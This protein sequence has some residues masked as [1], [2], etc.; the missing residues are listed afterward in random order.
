MKQKTF[1]QRAATAL[2][3][4]ALSATT[5]WAQTTETVS[6]IDADGHEQ[7]VT[8]TVLT[9]SENSLLN[10]PQTN[11]W[12]VVNSN[13][14]YTGRQINTANANII[15]KDNCTM[16]MSYDDGIPLY[17][18]DNL[19]IYGQSGGTGK[20]VVNSSWTSAIAGDVYTFTVNGGIVEAKNTDTY[21]RGL[22][23][24]SLVF[25]GGKLK[26][27][28]CNGILGK[29]GSSKT[30][31]LNW[32]N[33]TDRVYISGFN[34]IS[35]VTVGGAG[36]KCF[37]D[38]DGN[39][40]GGTYTDNFSTLAGKELQPATAYTLTLGSGIT[41]TTEP[42]FTY[43][44]VDY[45]AGTVTLGHADRTGYLF[46]GYTVNGTAIDGNTFTIT[47]D[48]TVAATFAP[49]P[50]HFSV[51]GDEYTIKTPAG[52]GVFCDALQDNDTYNRF[53]GKTVLLG[54]D[55]EVS[56]MAGSQYHDFCGT[57]DG[58][59][60]TLTF[61]YGEDGNPANDEYA[62]PFRNVDGC[63]IKNL[64]VAGDIY[65]SAKYAAGLV[66]QN[67]GELTAI[68]NCL[69]SVNIHSTVS[70]D[71]THGGFVAAASGQ[72]TITGCAFNGR[73][74][75]AATEKVGGF[76]GWRNSGAEI[77]NSLFIPAE[78][79][80]KSDGSATFA[81]NKVDTYNCYYTYPLFN[82]NYNPSYAPYDPADADH[83]DK[84]NNGH[85][86]RT[87]AAAEGVTI[88]VSPV[89]EATQTYTVS[90]ITAYATGITR[91]VGSDA[92]FYYGQGD[93]VGLKLSTTVDTNAPGYVFYYDA[94]AGTLSGNDT[95]GYTLTMPDA[96]VTISAVL[97]PIDW[98]T[99]STGA[100]WTNAYII[101]NK[102]QLDML[103]HRVNAGNH[104]NGKYFKLGADITYTHKDANAE[105]AATETNYTAIGY[106]TETLDRYFRGHFDGQGHT[107]SGIRIYKGGTDYAD[108]DQGLFG[109]IDGSSAEVK[110]VV[111]ADARITAADCIGGIV[112]YNRNGTV[113]GCHVLSDVTI[114]A[115][116]NE[117]SCFGGI[118]GY[119]YSYGTVAG[120]TSAASITTTGS[121]YECF[122]GVVG[123]NNATVSDCLYFGTTLEGTNNVGAIVGYN[124]DYGTV[125]NCYFTSTTITGKNDKGNALANAASAVGDNDGTVTQCGLARTVTA[126]TDVT[127]DAIA[128]TGNATTYGDGITDN[129]YRITAYSGGGIAYRANNYYGS[130]AVLSLTLSNNAG[131]APLGYQ[132]AY[133]AS[134]GTLSGNTLTMPDENVT[135][136]V[137]T[138][139]PRSTGSAVIVAYVDEN[140]QT[141]DIDAI[142]LDGTES[143]DAYGSVELAAGAYYVGTDINYTNYIDF[144]NDAILILGDG[145]TMTV[146][147]GN[148]NAIHTDYNLTIC[149][150]A[151]GTGKLNATST[152]VGYAGIRVING[153]LTIN[154]GTVTATA[155]NGDGT[156]I[157]VDNG[158]VT[159]NGGNVNANGGGYGI[160]ASN[161]IIDGGNVTANGRNCGIG[162]DVITLGWTNAS[163]HIYANSY[164]TETRIITINDGHQLTDAD[165]KHY[166]GDEW[167]VDIN[168]KHLY[169]YVENLNLAARQAPDGN[170]W[171]TF[172]CGHTSYQIDANENACAY[173]ATY[174]DDQLTLHRLGKAVPKA[175]AVIIVAD[176]NEV[177]MTAATLDAFTGSNDLRGVD[178]DS[179]VADIRNSLGEGT[180]YVLGMTTV[181][182]EQHFGFHRYTATEMPARKAFVHVA[183]A[184]GSNA[185]AL[186]RGISI[187]F[188][189]DA[190]GV[191]EVI[192]VSEVNDNSWYTINGVKLNGKPSK[193]GLYIYKGR[194]VVIK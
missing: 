146:N 28:G 152:K 77:R 18:G 3:T 31:T 75:G 22:I 21:G 85:A 89:G 115:V 38:A 73:L 17:L 167:A 193:S 182:N 102:D 156:G 80:V 153:N 180:L 63:T 129:D 110:N 5:A 15:L 74:L 29:T 112:G 83:P 65:T 35:S 116:Q 70:G 43:S 124:D 183:A 34:N 189:D 148:Y 139:H 155:T 171:T 140:G 23:C 97:D 46:S 154:G 76:I 72:I 134:A 47:A 191:E 64:H 132:Y 82:S 186:T 138:S 187:E 39:Y 147:Y 169:P 174:A 131:Q 93:A 81:R 12:F 42:L 50:D 172:Y 114:H 176:N 30:V 52:W 135:I 78:V 159:I 71:G 24:G 58:Q 96:D 101:Y 14:S 125:E 19:T 49:D 175:T 145:A 120:C 9:G 113:T 160:W 130:G 117:G 91:T 108:V 2:L 53:S 51:S 45:Y 119:N 170:Y 10:N 68:V 123:Q 90:G 181:N 88:D 105:G 143:V 103:A 32:R 36:G 118:V 188:G 11:G 26:L 179:P 192:E 79:T 99:Q 185:N 92:T 27:E 54:N 144:T 184:P 173:T 13:I 48:A 164:N 69:S 162:A 20:L 111:L 98:A 177:S 40:Y 87:V 161:V 133:T 67:S 66:A 44:D 86:T 106:E 157:D 104:Y 84:Y 1:I 56:R 4:I 7:T 61:N 57:F 100:D 55:I 94:G 41:T 190:T 107:V 168:G 141:Q 158:N 149:G 33:A 16:T 163:D 62:A 150:Q 165:G 178:T 95:D 194:K 126:G 109:F 60:N 25:N 6:Y 122:G 166:E 151:L 137:D 121:N 59:G 8:A 128:L 142:A 37:A 127:I 136:C